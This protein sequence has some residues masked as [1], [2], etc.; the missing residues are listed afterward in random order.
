MALALSKGESVSQAGQRAP[1]PDMALPPNIKACPA[2]GM[3][4]EKAG[5]DNSMMCGDIGRAAGGTLERALRVG[6]CGHEFDFATLAP[7][8]TG[9]PGQ[10]A[11]E[12]QV[13]FRV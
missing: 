6:G 5:G 1:A 2:C 9:R 8:G 12:R 10:P 7:N 11:N 13:N 3:L 4:L